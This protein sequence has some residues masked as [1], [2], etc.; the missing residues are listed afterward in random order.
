MDLDIIALTKELRKDEKVQFQIA[1]GN[2][3]KSVGTAVVLALFLGGLGAHKFYLGKPGLGVVYILFCWT[4]IPSFVAVIEACL[5][6]KSVKK[7][8][9]RK[10]LEIIEGIKMTRA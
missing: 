7:Y 9:N 4:F 5:M 2:E 6:S 8:N 10:A 1:Y 3:R